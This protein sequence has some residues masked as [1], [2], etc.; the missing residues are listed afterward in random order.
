MLTMLS[1][2]LAG[3]AA[4]PIDGTRR[5]TKKVAAQKRETA[6][7]PMGGAVRENRHEHRCHNR[8]ALGCH[9]SLLQ[10]WEL[11]PCGAKCPQK[12]H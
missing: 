1:S 9:V 6:S 11:R 2:T 3:H 10:N 7:F 12:R 5:G 8:C 4:I